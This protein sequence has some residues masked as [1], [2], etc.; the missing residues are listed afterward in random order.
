MI[1]P[2][3]QHSIDPIFHHSTTPRLIHPITPPPL[4]GAVDSRRMRLAFIQGSSGR[5]AWSGSWICC[6]SQAAAA[7]PKRSL[8]ISTTV[9]GGEVCSALGGLSHASRER[10]S[11][12]RSPCRVQARCAPSAS[13]L[14]ALKAGSGRGKLTN[15]LWSAGIFEVWC[16][17]VSG[18][19]GVGTRGC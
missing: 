16:R 6:W 2:S 18:R 4:G 7:A 8:A 10:S 11:G 13:S 3:I 5:T 1:P 15:L 17:S 14:L 12:M 9:S 19:R